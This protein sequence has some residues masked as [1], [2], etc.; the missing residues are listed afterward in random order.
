MRFG[1]HWVP[2]TDADD[3]SQRFPRT[4]SERLSTLC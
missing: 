3:E 1:R 4:A 2:E